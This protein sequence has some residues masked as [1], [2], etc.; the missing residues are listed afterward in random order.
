[1][2]AEA[3]Q[4]ATGV[5][6]HAAELLMLLAVGKV[7]AT[8]LTISSGGSG[9]VFGPSL[10]IG[11]MLGGSFGYFVHALFPSLVTET[12][13]VSLI[14]VGMG[15]F[16]AGV[17]KVPIASL[18][19]VTEMT[20]SYGLIV[21]LMVTCTIAFVLS[22][23]W[24]LYEE[25]VFT[26]TD[27][28]AHM[29]DFVVDVIRNIRVRDVFTEAQRQVQ[30]I[31]EDARLPDLFRL[32]QQSFQDY[33][34]VLDDQDHL[35]GILSFTDVRHHVTDDALGNLVLAGD[36]CEK[37]ILTTN[38]KEDLYSVLRKMGQRNIDSLPVVD[39]LDEARMQ[40]MVTRKDVILAYERR[41]S[42]LREEG[43]GTADPDEAQAI[44]YRAD[45]ALTELEV[46]EDETY[47]VGRQVREVNFPAGSLLVSIQRMEQSIIPN[48]L[49]R[50]EAGDRLLIVTKR[51]RVAE[52][53]RALASNDGEA[54]V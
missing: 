48:G 29:G 3:G 45:S 18:L 51:D 8:S 43:G 14:L 42:S 47:L 6:F 23:R 9:G 30:T 26:Q 52:V 10:Y 50:I 46:T 24:T 17:A 49:T 31:R 7:L 33:Y 12:A 21:P 32:F 22:Q 35:V 54:A 11:A 5:P 38:L 2:G 13:R 36:I 20:G 28:P 40:G 44:P 41:M 25:Q 37:Q 1:M 53:R 34:P 39:L 15:G 4:M 16:F 27:S 19:M